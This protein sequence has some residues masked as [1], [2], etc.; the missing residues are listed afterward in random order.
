MKPTLTERDRQRGRQLRDLHEAGDPYA[1]D[2]LWREF[3]IFI[4][5]P[6]DIRAGP[7]SKDKPGPANS[8]KIIWHSLISLPRAA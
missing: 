7:V 1:A 3:G 2:D 5:P 4:P 8:L 6:K